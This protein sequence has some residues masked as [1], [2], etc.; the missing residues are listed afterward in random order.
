MLHGLPFHAQRSLYSLQQRKL[1]VHGRNNRSVVL[2]QGCATI[3]KM[4]LPGLLHV[5]PYSY[6]VTQQSTSDRIGI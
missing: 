1:V 5:H 4:L 6:D 3:G 2:L